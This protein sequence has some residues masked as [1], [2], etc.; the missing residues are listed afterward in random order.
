M[1]QSGKM[2]TEGVY[3]ASPI[4]LQ[5]A[6]VAAYG[7]SWYRRRFGGPFQALLAELRQRDRWSAADFRSYQEAKLAELFSHAWGSPY[8]HGMFTSLGIRPSQ[9]P[10]EA[11]AKLPFLSKETLR[12]NP[13]SL[14]TQPPPQGTQVFKS[15]GTTGTPTEIYYPREF[16]SLELAIPAARNFDWAGIDYRARRVMFG[17]RKV[18]RFEQDQPPFWRHSPAEDLAYASIYHLSPRNIPAYLAFLRS[19]KPAVIMGYPSALGA[20]AQYALENQDSPAPA[21]GVFTTSETVTDRD[22]EIIQSAW[23]C[24][25]YDRYG[26][27]ENCHFAA[28]CEFGKYHVSPD[29][30]ILEIVDSTG[31]P[32]P[33]GMMGEVICTGLHNWLQPLIRYRIGDVARWAVDQ[34]CACGRQMPILEAIEGRVEDICITPDGRRLLRFDTV[35]KGVENIREAQVIQE[36]L[37]LFVI[38]VVPAENFSA[39]DIQALTHNMTRHVG[40]VKTEVQTVAAI[41]RTRSGKFRAVICNLPKNPG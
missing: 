28:Q 6:M 33:P 31:Q 15:S 35:F 3:L 40:T 9:P 29:V 18:C 2:L 21:Q 26:A 19:F 17:V 34:S 36:D 13:I 30:G 38:R 32:A 8:Y 12:S 39:K 11:L 14:L 16:H 5:Q 22:R 7:W 1:S 20:I 41:P 37:S 27:V 24:Q 4:W 23:R 25:V 10:L